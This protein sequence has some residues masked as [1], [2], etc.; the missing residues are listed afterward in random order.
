M[1]SRGRLRKRRKNRKLKD[2]QIK[3]NGKKLIKFI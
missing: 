2:K 1:D 3:K